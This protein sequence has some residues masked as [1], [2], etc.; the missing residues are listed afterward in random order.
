MGHQFPCPHICSRSMWKQGFSFCFVCL[1]EHYFLDWARLS[2]GQ[3]AELTLQDT[4]SGRW[5]SQD[6]KLKKIRQKELIPLLKL[7]SFCLGI[8]SDTKASWLHYCYSPFGFSGVNK[9]LLLGLADRLSS[10]KNW[11]CSA[12]IGLKDTS[13][14]FYC[15][16]PTI[17]NSI[18]HSRFF[19][20]FSP[21]AL[22]IVLACHWGK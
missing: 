5:I 17:T 16:K 9:T 19:P 10:F 2:L 3:L 11:F 8:C 20:F 7:P 14:F 15:L 13:L 6:F 22:N 21:P 4:S 12:T 1:A 18:F